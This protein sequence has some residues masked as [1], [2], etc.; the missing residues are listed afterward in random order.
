MAMPALNRGDGAAHDALLAAAASGLAACDA[1]MLAQF[2]TARAR[3]AVEAATGKPVLT[4]PDS[5][6]RAMRASFGT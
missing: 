3:A 6:V 4:S 5:A 2:S 1:I